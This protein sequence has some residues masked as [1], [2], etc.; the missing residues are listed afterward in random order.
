MP[1]P[2]D[3]NARRFYRVAYQRLEDGQLLMTKDFERPAAAIYLTGYA[4]ECMLKALL[5]MATPAR[6]RAEA[7]KSFRG[8]LAHDLLWLRDRLGS[9]KVRFPAVESKEL[10]YLSSWSTEMRYEPGPGDAEEA[11]RFIRAARVVVKW[12]DGRM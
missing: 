5:L 7:V 4:V 8:A 1:I 12:A 11:A 3:A 2:K 6:H 9:A 10:V